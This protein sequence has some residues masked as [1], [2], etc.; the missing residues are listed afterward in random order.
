MV[1]DSPNVGFV[2]A[3]SP[4]ATLITVPFSHYCEKARWALDLAGLP[5]REEGHVPALHM[6]ATF[7]AGGKR[8]VPV[9]VTSE[10][11]LDDSTTI[12][13]YANRHAPAGKKLLP[14]DDVALAEVR[15]LEE[16][17]DVELGPAIR[18]VLYFHLLPHP[19]LTLTL[20]KHGTPA[21]EHALVSLAFPLLRAGMRRRMRID[22]AGAER[23]RA[24]VVR[25]FDEV[26]QRLADGRRYLV[27]DRLTAADLTFAALVVPVVRPP[28]FPIPIPTLEEL[29]EAARRFVV[30]L[31]ET[32][33][34]QF[35]TR[36][37]KEHRPQASGPVG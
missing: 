1:R 32:P 29:P 9:L 10:G 3:T 13:E 11:V 8:T 14:T 21:W 19:A 18:R 7:G 27:G 31:A 25:I 2:P 16:R 28:E 35:A 20:M 23:S 15:A 37:Y 30:S 24:S 33:A 6:R 36:I 12:V 4:I 17:F 5:Y 26:N 34:G 22:E